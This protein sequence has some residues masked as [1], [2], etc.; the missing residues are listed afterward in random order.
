MINYNNTFNSPSFPTFWFSQNNSKTS[1]EWK[2][3]KSHVFSMHS[4]REWGLQRSFS[5]GMNH[6]LRTEIYINK[7]WKTTIQNVIVCTL[8]N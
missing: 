6:L 8:G 3:Y 1:H 2:Y 4:A 5:L 7:N